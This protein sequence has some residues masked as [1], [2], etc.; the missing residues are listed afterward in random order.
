MT[1]DQ[2]ATVLAKCASIDQRTIGRADVLAWHEIVGHLDHADALDAVK[3]WYAK[4]RDRIMP[5]DLIAEVRAIGNERAEK[6]KHPVRELPSRFETDEERNQRIANGVAILADH[7]KA[8]EGPPVSDTHG[9]ALLRAR[10][11]RGKREVPGQRGSRVGGRQVTMPKLPPPPWADPAAAERQAI[12]ALH[13]A[14]KV[15]GRP[16]CPR[17]ADRQ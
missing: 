1:P 15:C 12:E 3:R 11:E 4:T 7:W 16:V 17:C 5:S 9:Q 2:T 13:Q 14:G 10:R 8:P 6:T